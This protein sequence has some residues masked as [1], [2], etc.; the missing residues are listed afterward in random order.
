VLRIILRFFGFLFSWLAIGFIMAL[1]GVAAVIAIYGKDLPDYAQLENYEP[2][3]LSRIYSGQGLLMD[4]FARE[5]RIFTP[6]DEI[7][8]KV[9]QAFISAED[10]NFYEHHGFDPRGIAAAVYDSAVHG[11]RLRGAST[12]TQ[13]VMKNF[14]LTG[15]RSGE[16]KIKEIILATRLENTLSKDEILQLYLN[17]IFLGQNAYGVS[18][19][20]QTYFSKSLE[21][22]TLAETAYLAALP[23]APSML[24]PVREKAAAIA[25]RNYVLDQ[26]ARN[27]YVTR[28]EAAAAEKEDLLTV[29]SGDIVSARS[30]IPPRDYFTDE[31]RR[32]LSERFGD[33]Q[34]FTGGLTI[35]ATVDPELQA[36]AADAL[37][38]GLE[39][40]DRGLK[41]HRGP[42][43]QIDAA[44][45]DPNDEASWRKALSG[46]RVPR[47]IA[48]WHPAVVLA[49]DEKGARIGVEGVPAAPDG[50]RLAFAEAAWARV[51]AS[52]TGRLRAPKGP[53]DLWAVGDVVFVKAIEKDGAFD[54]WSYRQIPAI[55]GGFMAMDTQTG[56]VLAMQGGF[57][58]QSSVFN[59]AT[60]A[61]RQPGSSFKPFVY[62]AAL[63]QGYSPA[64]IVLDA[65]IEVATGA[66]I[67][68]PENSGNTYYGPTPMR[69]GIE[70]SRNLMT[71]RIAQDVGMDTVARYGE[72]FGIYDDMP[73][74][75]SYSLG[76]GETTLYKMVAAYAELANGGLKV[77]PTLVD[78]VQDRWGRTI[79]RHDQRDCTDCSAAALPPG[80]APQIVSHRERVIDPITAYQLTSM[81]QGVVQ[82]GTAAGHV[83]LPVPV[84]GKTGT[85]NDAKDVWFVGFTS[86][87]VAGC[88]I[89]YDR[90]RAMGGASGGGVCA[91][92]FQQFMSHAVKKYGG[93]AFAVPP[94]GHFLNIDR[95]SGAPL[96]DGASG[97]NVVAEYFRDGEDPLFGVAFDGGF[98][99]GANLPLFLPGETDATDRVQTP[100]GVAKIPGKASFGSLSSGGLY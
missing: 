83:N 49:L 56:R 74:L 97:P 47:D 2:A 57:S 25:R 70:Q 52:D 82:R 63:D 60:Q 51:R 12:I 95:Y 17:E 48:G 44:S 21:E 35:R 85:T 18:A 96:P 64:T 20:A 66:G 90:P 10:K 94:G 24:H 84:A 99:M 11:G 40:Y 75:L 76:A 34:L 7:P 88:Y 14:L 54:H 1:A 19:A 37:R 86:S 68:K 9:K 58:Y 4:E 73:P 72:R 8:D 23:Q 28:D 91:P 55:Q 45:F 50:D 39:Q 22:L 31:I 87:I 29:Q 41:V 36:V 65:P 42:V 5:R 3:T 62:A 53:A 33:E 92:V 16:R 77:E 100:T 59:R 78:R 38:D 43:A 30:E 46:T 81:L 93:T 6:I 61:L 71:V 32:Q 13:Q 67:W 69:T 27:G 79:Y 80:E 89:G 26:M 15:D 98:A